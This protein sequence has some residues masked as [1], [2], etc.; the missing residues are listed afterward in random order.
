MKLIELLL[1]RKGLAETFS[2]DNYHDRLKEDLRYYHA[3]PTQAID[4]TSVDLIESAK[5]RYEFTIP[6]IFTNHESMMASMFDRMPEIVFF[7]SGKDDAGKELAVRASYEYLKDKLDLE[8][9]ANDA[10][11]WF[12]LGGFVSAH[13]GYEQKTEDRPVL[14]EMTGEPM[15]DESGETKTFADY[16]KD[17]PT[18]EVDD[19]FKVMFSPESEFDYSAK[20]VPYYIRE[21]LMTTDE[22]E[23]TFKPKEKVEADAT[24]DTKSGL[25]TT[26]QEVK[27]DNDRVRVFFYYGSLPKTVSGEVKEWDY[28]KDYYIVFT[29]KTI[30]H[31]SESP[32]GQKMCRILKWHGA[33]NEFYGFGIGKLLRPFQ[34]EKSIRRGQQV[35][36][37]DVAA[38]PKLL[39]PNDMEYDKRSIRDPRENLVLL[40]ETERGKPEYL[41]APNIGSAVADANQ[42][43][44]QD[45]QQASGMMDIST[46]SQQSATVDTATGQTIFADAAEKRMRLAKKKFLKFYREC[47]I[48]LLKLAQE[49]WESD[50]LV[51]IMGE[52]GEQIAM[53]VNRQSLEDIDFDTDVD[54]DAESVTINKDVIRQQA[55]DLYDRVK[56]D[57]LVNRK[58]VFKYMLENGFEIRN[59]ERFM[60]NA[61]VPP[62]TMLVDPQTGQQFVVGESGELVD[63]A[64]LEGMREPTEGGEIPTDQAGISGAVNNVGA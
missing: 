35:R 36:F 23:R 5:R 1:Q 39:L 58:E 49:N 18:I 12:I 28:D 34:R 56:D 19:P 47:V 11:W 60:Q 32:F 22:V 50:R 61:E 20:R 9:F 57:P 41:A 27:S 54:I 7:Q 10:A 33:P 43:A 30:L 51:H 62:G 6:L 16:V 13:A 3:Q 25:S 40:Y 63:A 15:M 14:D 38:F 45:A 21:K 17:D 64:M 37:A 24:I 52:N 29:A 48:L 55:I 2:Q 8:T 26:K 59:G 31:K 53:Q 42:Q 44:D 4:V 46:G